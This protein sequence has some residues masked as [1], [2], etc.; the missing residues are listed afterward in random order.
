MNTKYTNPVSLDEAISFIEAKRW[1]APNKGHE[2][3]RAQQDRVSYN[4]GIDEALVALSY[5][6]RLKLKRVYKKRKVKR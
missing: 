3:L 6:K 4:E 1:P 2:S 5:C